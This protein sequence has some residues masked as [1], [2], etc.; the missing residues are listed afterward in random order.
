MNR[1]E[2]INYVLK[3][4]GTGGIYDFGAT[5]EDV[6]HAL[7]IRLINHADLDFVGDSVDRELVRD[8]MLAAIDAAIDAEYGAL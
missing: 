2:F 7:D 1:N 8:I 5:K 6:E 3:F 4:Y